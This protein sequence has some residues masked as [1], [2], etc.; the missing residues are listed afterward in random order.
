ML[1]SSKATLYKKKDDVYLHV[2]LHYIIYLFKTKC[3]RGYRSYF[4][5]IF[6]AELP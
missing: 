4:V 2:C 1:F 5:V 3:V 6:R